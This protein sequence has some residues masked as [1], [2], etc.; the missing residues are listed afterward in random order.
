MDGDTY[1]V[2]QIRRVRVYA[3]NEELALARANRRFNETVR[4][5]NSYPVHVEE[6]KVVKAR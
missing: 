5:E 1:D 3:G 6:V 4:P 2:I